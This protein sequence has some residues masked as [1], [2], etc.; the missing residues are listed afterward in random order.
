MIR[1]HAMRPYKA[2][3]PMSGGLFVLRKREV[4]FRM[5]TKEKEVELAAFRDQLVGAKAVVISHNKGLTVGEVTE[6]RKKLRDAG[7]RHKVVKN[8]L[9]KIAAKEAGMVG[10]D[11]YLEGPTVISSTT[12][13]I[14]APARILAGYAKDH[15]KLV[16]MGGFIEGKEHTAKDIIAIS[17]LPSKEEL[18]AKLLGSLNS[19]ISGFV[20]VLNGPIS[21]FVRALNAI[22]Q[23]KAAA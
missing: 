16:I 18:L 21:G 7:I 20:R 12:G 19:P 13:D 3:R 11:K 23:K 22:A 15:E 10:L 1:A 9:A 17:V 14:V 2:T 6:L 8:T 4:S 5:P